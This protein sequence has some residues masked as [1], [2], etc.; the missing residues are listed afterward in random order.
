LFW[1]AVIL[2]VFGATLVLLQR[3]RV[4]LDVPSPCTY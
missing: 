2:V 4:I 1:L 3:P